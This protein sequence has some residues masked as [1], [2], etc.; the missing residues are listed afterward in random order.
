MFFNIANNL[1]FVN[2]NLF[3]KV[4]IWKTQPIEELFGARDLL[5]FIA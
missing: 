2:A 3:G 4:F 5:R 1:D